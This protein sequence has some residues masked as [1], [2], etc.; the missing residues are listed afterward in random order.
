MQTVFWVSAFVIVYAYAGYPLLPAVW[1]RNAK[2]A[3]M[4]APVRLHEVRA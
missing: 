4:P 3:T 1:A 2:P